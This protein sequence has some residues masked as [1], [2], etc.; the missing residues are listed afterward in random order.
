MKE[1]GSNALGRKTDLVACDLCNSYRM[2]DERCSIA[3][4]MVLEGLVSDVVRRLDKGQSALVKSREKFFY[5]LHILLG[6]VRP[7]K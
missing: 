3:S 6:L 1:Y 5:T 4:L 7:I 2:L